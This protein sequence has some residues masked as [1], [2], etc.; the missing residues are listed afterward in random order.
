MP[1]YTV[2][3]FR[4]SGTGYNATYNTSY[5]A[6]LDDDDASYQ[7]GSDGNE[8]VS[9]N[10]GGFVSTIGQPYVI[11]VSFTDTNG[12][13]HVEDFY[14]FNASG[15]GGWY[16]VPEPG[17]A[18][19]VGATLGSY[20]SHT[21]GWDYSTVT[22]FVT[23]THITTPKGTRKVED[24]K[25]GDRVLAADGRVLTLRQCLRRNVS[26]VEIARHEKLRPVCLTAGAL[27]PGIPKRDLRVSRQHRMLVRSAV[28]K[29]MFGTTDV[30]VA[31]IRLTELP[32]I[33]VD[34]APNGLGY[35]HLVF[36]QHEVV[37]AEGAPSESFYPG[38]DALETIPE[39]SRAE[40]KRLFP[41]IACGDAPRAARTIPS[42]HRQKRLVARLVKNGQPA[43]CRGHS[44]K[45]RRI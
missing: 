30:L 12:D 11:S 37:L 40:L 28:A 38:P 14:F 44:Q 16:F 15:A 41:E 18:F 19:T 3:A 10:G 7:G 9:I 42:R 29:R 5:T 43:F 1:Q 36:D 34:P 25:P 4:W 2:E 39:A 17:S 33:Y 20:Q 22:C 8:S 32:G 35:V 23:G 45:S 21:V 27:G 31:A 6:V 26:S 24:L 13:P